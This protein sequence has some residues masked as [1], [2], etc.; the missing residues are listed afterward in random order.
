[1]SVE[2]EGKLKLQDDDRGFWIVW[3]GGTHFT[4]VKQNGQKLG[5]WH[6]DEEP[7]EDQA[8]KILE[9]MK[10]TGEYLHIMY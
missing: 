2:L 4:V 3:K 10:D 8:Q 6:E 5:E 1:M 7:A 9:H